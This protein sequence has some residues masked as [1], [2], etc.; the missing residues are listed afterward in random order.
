MAEERVEVFKM[1]PDFDELS[2]STPIHREEFTSSRRS[3]VGVAHTKPGLASEWHHH[4]GND[5]YGYVISGQIRIEFGPNGKNS[6]AIGPGESFHMPSKIIHREV[7]SD[8]EAGVIF[9]VR[10]GTGKP[11]VRVKGPQ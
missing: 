9:L 11:V 1:S 2:D 8:E 6:V 10:V 4:S 5:T 3:W 7:T